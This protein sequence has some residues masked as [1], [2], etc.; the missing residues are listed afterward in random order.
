MTSN[1]RH[2]TPSRL[3]KLSGLVL[4]VTPFFI[5][6]WMTVDLWNP[7]KYPVHLHERN[8]TLKCEY[9]KTFPLTKTLHAMVCIY[10]RSMNVQFRKL[11]HNRSTGIQLDP[12][13]GYYLKTT[14][15]FIDRGLSALQSRCDYSSNITSVAQDALSWKTA[16]MT[17]RKD[18]RKNYYFFHL[19]VTQTAVNVFQISET[20]P[21]VH[22]A[23]T[24]D[25]FDLKN[26][27]LYIKAKILRAD[28][29]TLDSDEKVG[30]VNNVYTVCLIR[31]T[32]LTTGSSCPVAEA[33]PTLIKPT[34]KTC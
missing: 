34:Y 8:T 3:A 30:P 4:L 24:G 20:R 23:G 7:A 17:Y 13:H 9:T 16:W 10:Q 27:W 1:R 14:L 2:Y 28:G 22:V 5:A 19:P 29:T 11:D 18:S 15:P 25:Y 12:M 33:P 21:V 32:F 31:L 26:S 6:F